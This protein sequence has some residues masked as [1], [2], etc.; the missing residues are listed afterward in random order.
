M[1]KLSRNYVYL[2]YICENL[3]EKLFVDKLKTHKTNIKCN[4]TTNKRQIFKNLIQ[5]KKKLDILVREKLKN[6]KKPE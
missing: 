1:K 5:N 3:K 4:Q 6:T 2:A